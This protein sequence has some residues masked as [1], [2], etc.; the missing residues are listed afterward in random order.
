MGQYGL[1]GTKLAKEKPRF[2]RGL[3]LS[4]G[5]GGL[6]VVEDSVGLVGHL[7]GQVDVGV[8]GELV[9]RM[10]EDLLDDDQA[11]SRFDQHAR[12]CVSE[13]VEFNPAELQGVLDNSE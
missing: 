8:R 5:P 1:W 4:S 2:W 11:T 13:V 10:A 3:S 9:V 12:A 7:V 6:K